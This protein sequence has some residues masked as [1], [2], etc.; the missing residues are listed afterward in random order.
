[1]PAQ[2]SMQYQLR[3]YRVI[4]FIYQYLSEGMTLEPR[5]RQEYRQQHR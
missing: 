4:D 1:M 3:L 5:D 2:T